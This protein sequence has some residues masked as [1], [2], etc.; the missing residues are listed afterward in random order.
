M[1]E[2]KCPACGGELAF[3]DSTNSRE[4]KCRS[5]YYTAI[6]PDY[7]RDCYV[8]LDR[9]NARNSELLEALETVLKEYAEWTIDGPVVTAKTMLRVRDVIAKAKGD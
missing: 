2:I 3:V 7:R 6:F 5:C 4:V 9:L 1:S 8:E